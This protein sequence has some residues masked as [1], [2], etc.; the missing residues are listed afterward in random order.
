M[1]IHAFKQVLSLNQA[2]YEARLNLASVYEINNDL[3]GAIE[4]YQC[5]LKYAKNIAESSRV[6]ALIE[7]LQSKRG[8]KEK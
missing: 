5:C 1:A 2:D 8:V 3:L 7:R 6:K 4:Q